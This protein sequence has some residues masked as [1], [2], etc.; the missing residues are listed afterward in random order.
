MRQLFGADCPAMTKPLGSFP[1]LL[2]V[3]AN[4]PPGLDTYTPL[5]TTMQDN[6]GN[7]APVD[8][9]PNMNL[10]TWFFVVPGVMLVLTAANGPGPVTYDRACG[11]RRPTHA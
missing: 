6:V 7:Y 11:R 3:L 1:R 8:S 9:L 4:V 2:P 10:F 5:L